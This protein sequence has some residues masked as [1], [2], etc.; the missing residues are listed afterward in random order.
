M[1]FR[2]IR[3]NGTRGPWTAVSSHTVIGKTAPPSDVTGFAA[4]F[5]GGL[6]NF[7]W[8]KVSD[9]DVLAYEIRYGSVGVEWANA[10]VVV[11]TLASTA[12]VTT[13]L[14]VGTW[15]VLIKAVDIVG[16]YSN[17]AVSYTL[18]VPNIYQTVFAQTHVGWPGSKTNYVE[19]L[20]TGHLNT[21]STLMATGNNFALFNSYVASACATAMY[22][23][24][25]ISLGAEDTV[26]VY[27]NVYGVLGAGETGVISPDVQ[28]NTGSGWTNWT[29]GTITATAV[30]F[31]FVS[32][33]SRGLFA[34]SR[35]ECCIDKE[36][37]VETAELVVTATGVATATFS[38]KFYTKPLLQVSAEAEG[39]VPRIASYSDVT[40]TY[41]LGHIH[42]T[43]GTA[44]SGVLT[45]TA[46]SKG[47]L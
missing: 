21:K 36:A 20:V 33:A 45:Y 39:G 12:T 47:D 11:Q 8:D 17:A 23:G 7:K 25:T 14:P 22:A 27:A 13:L 16:N 41:F 6:V 40:T 9:V 42:T 3:N 35:F 29:I 32:P 10:T 26:R 38:N 37:V 1:K 2:F 15:D 44:T 4:S 43:N 31:R 19:N 18:V 28:I 30:R 46:S 24:A 34:A 5:F